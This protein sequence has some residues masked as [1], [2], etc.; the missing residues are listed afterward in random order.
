MIIEWRD[1][2]PPTD[3]TAIAKVEA[4]WGVMFPDDFVRCALVNHGGSPRPN[5]F[6]VGEAEE[7]FD[8]LLSFKEPHPWR[9]SNPNS[10]TETYNA[11]RGQGLLPEGVY[12]FAYDPGGNY[13]AF[14]YRTAEN[15]PIIVFLAHEKLDA[16]GH[17]EAYSVCDSFTALLDS[18]HPF[19]D[20]E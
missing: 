11:L 16:N 14:D 18:L 3:R 20:G 10:I 7:V 5:C 13:L 6:L 19:E 12:P 2:D 9:V 17:F 8:T 1:A 4:A 15:E